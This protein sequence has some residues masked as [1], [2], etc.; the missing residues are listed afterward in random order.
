MSRKILAIL[1]L[2][3]L[4]LYSCIEEN[5]ITDS[6][7][8]ETSVSETLTKKNKELLIPP[9][10]TPYND[11]SQIGTMALECGYKTVR[12]WAITSYAPKSGKYI[13]IFATNTSFGS[14]LKNT[15][16]FTQM[17][18]WD[19]S[20][21]NAAKTAGFNDNNIMLIIPNYGSAY[22][23]IN[24]LNTVQYY[25]VD[26]PFEREMYN[27]TTLRAVAT[28]IH[29]ANP[30][31]KMLMA[32]YKWPTLPYDLFPLETYGDKYKS[33]LDWA[34]NSYIMCDEYPGN[35]YGTT[36]DYWSK[37]KEYYEANKNFSNWI[38]IFINNTSSGSGKSFGE[39]LG[40]ANN[41]G[42]NNIWLYAYDISSAEYT[43]G[44]CNAAFYA[45]WLRAFAQNIVLVYRCFYSDPCDC[46]VS[47]PDGWYLDEVHYEPGKFEVFP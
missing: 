6:T 47:L 36:R 34:S 44:F 38:S 23:L 21:Y 16:G 29:D 42:I 25:H 8:K 1:Y 12:G 24:T 18:I 11:S 35:I 19:Q 41:L 28:M 14:K 3:T 33:V 43:D 30:N 17:A 46:N 10:F 45:G 27:T 13:G 37:Y 26:E 7:L 40:H 2:S 5:N 20:S 32:S 9:G 4:L 39:L 22:S 15:Y 31:G